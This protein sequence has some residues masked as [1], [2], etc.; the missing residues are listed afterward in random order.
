MANANAG[1]PEVKDIDEET[2]IP[3]DETEET[4]LDSSPEN[5][6]E[7]DSDEDEEEDETPETTPDVTVAE[8]PGET[9]RER[10]L[11][12]EVTRLKGLGREEHKKDMGFG[13]RPAAPAAAPKENEVLKK[14]NPTE[15]A[16]LREVLPALAE[17][18]GY[19][20]KDD[21]TM[22]SYKEKADDVLNEFLDAHP[23]YLPENDKDNVLWNRFTEELKMFV[24]PQNPKEYKKLFDRV[25][26]DI[27]GIEI[28]GSLPKVKAGQEKIKVASH[29]GSSRPANTMPARNRNASTGLRTDALKGLLT[30]KHAQESRDSRITLDPYGYRI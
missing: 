27:L 29:A 6:D 10:A 5:E 11:R 12:L 30:S 2:I 22:S 26:R 23:E 3:G 28:K 15:I 7:S 1:E 13:K 16:A 14:Y 25:H 20:R 21:L 24:T 8:V 4:D 18:M 19:V 17:E 9:P